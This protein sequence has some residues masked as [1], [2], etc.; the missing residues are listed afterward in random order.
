[1][2]MSWPEVLSAALVGTDRRPL[3]EGDD[4][5]QLL[6]AAAAWSVYRRAGVLPRTDLGPPAP[7]PPEDRPMVV[8]AAAARGGALLTAGGPYD[9]GTRSALL[10]EW[11]G[12]V[13]EHGQRVP[14]EF[15]P[16]LFDLSRFQST[17]RPLVR[18]AGGARVG[19][20][21][22]L[23][24]DWARFVGPDDAPPRELSERAWHEGGRARR[25]AYLAARRR[26]DPGAAR[27]LLAADWAAMGQDERLDLIDV[28]ADGLSA[29]DEPFLEQA[30]D[31]RRPEVRQRAA[32]LLGA[33]PGSEFNRRMVV[34][35]QTYLRIEEGRLVVSPPDARDAA[36]AR[37][38]VSDPPAGAPRRPWW[39][40]EVLTRTPLA[41]LTS[42]P[43]PRFLALP[44]DD[45][46][47]PVLLRA[48]A[49]AAVRQQSPQWATALL[50][51]V[52]ADQAR[53]VET[54]AE[55]LGADELHRRAL[56]ALTGRPPADWIAALNRCP[57]PWSAELAA[58]ALKTW[59]S[60]ATAPEPA[61]AGP[62]AV[63]A[64][65]QLTRAL[66]RLSRRAALVMPP[67]LAGAAT[68]AVRRLQEGAQPDTRIDP[69]AW[70]ASVLSFR[71]RMIEEIQST[72]EMA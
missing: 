59:E 68:A 12:L 22:G 57:A 55:I 54:L 64:G 27:A 21:A 49:G 42:L 43:P 26:A 65:R 40:G 58:T 71:H 18:A 70:V 29:D 62:G 24:P 45:E 14:P 50:D 44:V 28:L 6:D 15:L 19:W 7:A 63:L 66:D 37:D 23:N 47:R 38:G 48:L 33:L 8:P 56:A 11:L 2:N 4:P 60:V 36:M 10:T 69:L 20:L 17:L 46:W 51:V 1:M 25:R 61:G 13:A 32:D 53:L 41:A 72:Q 9:G 16:D 3:S 67:S 5:A 35:A 34:R 52:S 31:D 39:L 30:L